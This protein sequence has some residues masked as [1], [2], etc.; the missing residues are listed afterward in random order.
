MSVVT[1]DNLTTKPLQR[2]GEFLNTNV[3]RANYASTNKYVHES[4]RAS[5]PACEPR[6]CLDRNRFP[7]CFQRGTEVTTATYCDARLHR[8]VAINRSHGAAIRADGSIACWGHNWSGEAPPEGIAGTFVS[9]AVGNFTTLGLRADGSVLCVGREAHGETGEFAGP[10]V[11]IA[12]GNNFWIGLRAD[13]N[14]DV[15]GKGLVEYPGHYGNTHPVHRPLLPGQ[16]TGPFIAI[17]A[18]DNISVVAIRADGSAELWGGRLQKYFPTNLPG[19]YTGVATGP[20]DVLLLRANGDAEYHEVDGPWHFVVE[21]GEHSVVIPGPF[22]DVRCGQYAPH[23]KRPGG[24]FELLDFGYVPHMSFY[25]T[26][27]PPGGFV[28]MAVERVA[29]GVRLDGSLHVWKHAEDPRD[30]PGIGVPGMYKVAS[31]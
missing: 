13:G 10:Y 19:P 4:M 11:E 16:H 31:I 2:I 7:T 30:A 23:G 1:F 18:N 14:L 6:V 25:E 21:T 29:V 8:T 17:S 9:V 12:G 26:K 24:T 15:V 20:G 27:M 5:A 22:V 28:D 3:D